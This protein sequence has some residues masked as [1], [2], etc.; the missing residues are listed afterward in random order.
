[1]NNPFVMFSRCLLDS[2]FVCSVRLCFSDRCELIWNQN[3]VFIRPFQL[4]FMDH[5]VER[6]TVRVVAVV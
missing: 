6:G 4:L 1:M 5:L 2:G 3:T